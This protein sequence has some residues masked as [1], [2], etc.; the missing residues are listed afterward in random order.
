MWAQGTNREIELCPVH[1]KGD[2]EPAPEGSCPSGE[3]RHL[4]VVS[5]FEVRYRRLT[6]AESVGYLGL[7]RSERTAKPC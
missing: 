2:P 3:G 5:T 7:G 1:V 6:H 4:R